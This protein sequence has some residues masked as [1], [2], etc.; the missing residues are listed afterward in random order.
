MPEAA[1]TILL[2]SIALAKL[3]LGCESCALGLES[4]WEAGLLRLHWW[5]HA[6]ACL[7]GLHI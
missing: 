7:L 2:L 3:A 6:E 4:W 5:R 1:I